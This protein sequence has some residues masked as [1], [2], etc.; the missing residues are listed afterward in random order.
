MFG[1]M[2]LMLLRI[3]ERTRITR[4]TIIGLP[5]ETLTRIQVNG[6]QNPLIMVIEHLAHIGVIRI[7]LILDL[8][9]NSN[10][11]TIPVSLSV[12]GYHFRNA[13]K[14]I[15]SALVLAVPSEYQ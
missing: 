11:K 6:V 7:N 15:T 13:A 10:I 9:T 5:A 12:G 8:L 2:G 4:E 3:F 1:K 14:M